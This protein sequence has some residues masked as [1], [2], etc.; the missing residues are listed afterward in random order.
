MLE[1]ANHSFLTLFGAKRQWKTKY[2][3]IKMNY[4]FAKSGVNKV[5]EI[6]RTKMSHPYNLI[7]FGVYSKQLPTY[8]MD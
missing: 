7:N 5:F 4:L 2:K 1:F 8:I 6:S 3:M